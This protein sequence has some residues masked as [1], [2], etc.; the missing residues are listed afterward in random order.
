[1]A[2]SAFEVCCLTVDKL[3]Q[4]CSERG[5]DSRGFVRTLWQRLAEHVKSNQMEMLCDEKMSQAS[6]QTDLVNNLVEPVPLNVGCCSNGGGVDSQAQ[7][8]VE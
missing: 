7:V 3:C 1:M 5:L 6:V 4:V 2:L 8:L